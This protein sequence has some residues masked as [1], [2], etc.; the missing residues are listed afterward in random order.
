MKAERLILSVV[1]IVVGLIAAGVAFYLYQMTIAV[2]PSKNK[3]MTV[4]TVVPTPTP[5]PI[6]ENYLKVD[7]PKDESVTAN[8][9]I[10][11]T[12]KTNPK[13]TIIVSTESTD[14]VVTPASNGDFTLSIPIDS[15]TN[16]IQITS[17]F[18]NGEETKV[19]RSVTYSTEN[20]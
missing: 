9:T 20:F 13:S 2:P 8:K 19:N 17:V 7:N 11:I 5:T 4:K 18:P 10:N 1:A 12:G 15:G 16:F 6:S 14:Q 3:E